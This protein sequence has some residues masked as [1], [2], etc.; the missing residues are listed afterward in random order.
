MKLDQADYQW[1]Q[2]RLYV[3]D[4]DVK[5]FFVGLLTIKD[6]FDD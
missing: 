3:N 4:N 1:M 6:F 2:D 5:E